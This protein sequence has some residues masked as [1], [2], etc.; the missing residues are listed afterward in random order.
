MSGSKSQKRKRGAIF[1]L[2]FTLV[3]T[4]VKKDEFRPTYE[5][6]GV[7]KS[8]WRKQ[9]FGSAHKRLIGLETDPYKIVGTMARAIN[10]GISERTIRIATEQRIAMFEHILVDVPD[11]SLDILIRLRHMG[12]KTALITN[13]DVI[14]TQSWDASPLAPLFDVTVLSWRVGYAKPDKRIYDHCMEQIGLPVGECIFVG[15]GGSDELSGASAVGLTPI[16][17]T[18]IMPELEKD[19]IEAREQIAE[20]TISQLAELLPFF[21]N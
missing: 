18:G 1:D 7:E 12:A 21:E 3:S 20:H 8:E 6:L 19:E 5:I 16:F 14:E 11:A 10:P 2:F 13:A 4:E 17:T 15:D 9:T